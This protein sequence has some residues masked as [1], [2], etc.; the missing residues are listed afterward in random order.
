MSRILIAAHPSP[1]HVN[2][3]L[4]IAKYLRDQDHEILFLTSSLFEDRA[5]ECDLRF[6]PLRGSANHDYRE[7]TKLFPELNVQGDYPLPINGYLKFFS[8]QI[9]EQY[10]SV[11]AILETQPV[12][13]IICDL[14]FVGVLALLLGSPTKRPPVI[15]LGVIAPSL[16]IPESSPFSGYDASPRGLRRNENDNGRFREILNPGLKQIDSAL[17][18]LGLA[19]PGGFDFTSLYEFSDAF[20][21]LSTEEFDLPTSS[22]PKN[23]RFVGPLPPEGSGLS[24]VTP[25]DWL[26]Q[27]NGTRP[28]V[29]VSQ[30]VIANRDQGQLLGPAIEAFEREEIE[31]VVTQGGRPN[32]L[33]ANRPGVHVETYLPYEMILPK[34]DVF[35]TNGGFN[36]V[37]QALTFGV[38]IVLAGTTEEKK[39][40]G[41]RVSRSGVG[42]DLQTST[43]SQEQIHE[44]V[45]TVLR[46]PSF[47]RKAQEFQASFATYDALRTISAVSERLMAG[48][49][50]PSQSSVAIRAVESRE[51][52]LGVTAR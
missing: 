3:V 4:R 12:D 47:R 7:R 37:Q 36:G 34:T 41:H 23:F 13:L 1:G 29:F 46:D 18:E 24:A 5:L 11:L 31:L 10:Q 14:M 27:L 44:A 50:L 38:P 17:A 22:L 48:E 6:V 28:V 39:I 25:P 20:L 26:A 16:G 2:P 35:L 15:T 51:E 45:F 19:V 42:L 40:V 9:R 52:E 21:Q 43:P 8:R 33:P 32:H 49:M 30:G